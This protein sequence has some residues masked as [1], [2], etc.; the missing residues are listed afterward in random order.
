MLTILSFL[1]LLLRML[2]VGAAAGVLFLR[3]GLFLRMKPSRVFLVGFGAAPFFLSLMDYLLGFVFVGWPSWFYLL[4]PALVSALF[5]CLRGSRA[6]LSESLGALREGL[7]GVVKRSGKW[8]PF[9][10]AIAALATAVFFVLY[11]LG[12]YL[13]ELLTAVIGSAM[14]EDMLATATLWDRVRYHLDLLH[15]AAPLLALAGLAGLVLLVVF[16]RGMRKDKTLWTNVFLFVVLVAA[17]YNLVLGYGTNVRPVVDEDRS[18]YELNARYFVEDKD[19]FEI[20]N[21]KDEKYGS[22]LRDDHGP[23]WTVLLAD[24]RMNADALGIEDSLRTDNFGVFCVYCGFLLMLFLTAEQLAHT[25]AA[26][27]V[28]WVLFGFYD[29]YIM[30]LFGS[31]DAFRFIGLLLLLLYAESHLYA[32]REKRAKWFHHLFL[33]LLCYFCMNGHEGNIYIMFGMFLAMGVLMLGLRLPFAQ[34]L[35]CGASALAGT[36]LGAEKAITHLIRE[37]TLKSSTL[38]PFHDTPIIDQIA[39]VNANRADWAVIWESYSWYVLIAVAIGLV[40]LLALAVYAVRKKDL[41]RLIIA[42]LILG[43]LLPLTGLMD[44]LGYQCSVWFIEQYRYRMYF[45]MLFA[46]TGGWMLTRRGSR[47]ERR[48]TLSLIGSALCFVLYLLI[49]VV[50]VTGYNRVDMDSYLQIEAECRRIADVA[51]A[52][53]DGDVFTANRVLLYYLHGTPKLLYHNMSEPLIQAKTDE[54]IEAALDEMNVGAIIL[55]RNGKKYH[56]YACL[57]FWDYLQRSE[58]VDPVPLGGDEPGD[59]VLFVIRRG[60]AD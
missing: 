51:D 25:K 19:S 15:P 17:G 57:P 43:M 24:F 8:F 35:A 36:L 58:R 53:E 22:S 28:A 59:Q 37:G 9:L 2:L 56:D 11:Q 14:Q 6:R 60:A 20:D 55:P 3:L 29:K 30:M 33:L 40:S 41:S 42:A 18:H 48:E 32:M 13:G 21:Y 16:V 10:A 50:R 26:G 12:L 4:V 27:A 47:E 49:A 54:E 31:R 5:L 7:G 23:L 52:V 1:L 44:F 34:I 38:Q 45:L 39:Q 46:V